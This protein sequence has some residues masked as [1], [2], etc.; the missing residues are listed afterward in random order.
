[1]NRFVLW[2]AQ[3]GGVGRIPI[4]PGTFGSVVGVLWFVL[5]LFTGDIWCF[6]AIT[7]AVQPLS[8]WICGRAAQI[9]R[10]RDPPSVVLDEIVAVPICFLGWLGI[11]VAK[12]GTFPAP[13]YFV[14]EQTWLLTVAVFASFRFFDVVKPWP[15]HQSESLRR[16]WGI[17]V[18]DALA[19]VY[20]NAVVLAA[21]AGKA[22][23]TR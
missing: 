6:A 8:A 12:T 19:A 3:G 14:S 2:V 1:M 5:L 18:D 11:V 23:L 16:G 21:Y 22:I 13:K 9:L 4:A 10:D 15:V 20:A 7:I 17:T